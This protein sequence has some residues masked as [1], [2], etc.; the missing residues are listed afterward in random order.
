[1]CVCVYGEL[2]NAVNMG[3]KL[4]D[5][6]GP[7]L[8]LKYLSEVS[9]QNAAKLLLPLTPSMV[10]KVTLDRGKLVVNS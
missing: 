3:L 1:V 4:K 9:R 10:S 2:G 5:P 8:I 7:Q 6:C